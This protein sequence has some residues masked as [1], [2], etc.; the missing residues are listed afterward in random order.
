[1]KKFVI[2]SAVFLLAAII[3]PSGSAS[4]KYNVSKPTVTDGNPMPPPIPPKPGALMADGAG[5]NAT[6][7]RDFASGHPA[8][9]RLRDR[10]INACLSPLMGCQQPPLC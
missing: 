1:M 6:T 2:L 7:N 10:W 5:L 4:G 9:W 3:L 8:W